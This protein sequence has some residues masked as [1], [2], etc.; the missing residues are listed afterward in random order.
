MDLESIIQSIIKRRW[1]AVAIWGAVILIS[2]L[3]VIL[4]PTLYESHGTFIVRPIATI[5]LSD[6]LVNAIDTLSRRVEIGSTYAEVARSR[7]V[8]EAVINNLDLSRSEVENLKVNSSTISGT[9]II[10]ISVVASS[11]DLALAAATDVAKETKT[12]IR[13]FYDVFELAPLDEFEKPNRPIDSNKWL[14]IILGIIVGGIA[15]LG[16]VIIIGGL[17][18]RFGET[19]K[20]EFIDH[21]SG[22]FTRDY[23][24]HRLAQEISR[25]SHKHYPFSLA[26]VKVLDLPQNGDLP[27]DQVVQVNLGGIYELLRKNFREEDVIAQYDQDSL[28]LLIPDLIGEDIKERMKSLVQEKYSED[29]EFEGNGFKARDDGAQDEDFVVGIVSVEQH[30]K[31]I[32]QLMKLLSRA[33]YF[34]SEE[35]NG[36]IY[37]CTDQE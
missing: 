14:I 27:A 9:N 24:E 36:G 22:I 6:E 30:S 7:R 35:E 29:D 18:H 3:Y 25:S 2:V 10:Q 16:T 19:G 12:S 13:E 28:A 15:G 31:N 5:T 4:S 20:L 1:I 11:P 37:F 8:K 26:M 17:E 21:Q 33:V 34:A 23:F 32:E